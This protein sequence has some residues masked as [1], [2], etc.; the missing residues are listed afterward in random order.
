MARGLD[1]RRFLELCYAT[2]LGRPADARGVEGHLSSLTNQQ[3]DMVFV[4]EVFDRIASSPEYAQRSRIRALLEASSALAND[5]WNVVG[6]GTHCL[7]ATLLRDLQLRHFSLPFDW[8]FSSPEMV[9]HALHDDFAVFLDRSHH[10]TVPEHQRPTPGANLA[11]HT[12]YRENFGVD[13]VFNHH[14]PVVSDAAY[15]YLQRSVQRFRDLEHQEGRK[16]FVLINQ[17][18]DSLKTGHR[19]AYLELTALLK[20][21][22]HLFINVHQL[23]TALSGF[24]VVDRGPNYEVANFYSTSELKGIEFRDVEDYVSLARAVVHSLTAATAAN[25]RL[26]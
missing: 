8:I 4:S 10:V 7:T 14:D 20:G 23:P 13:Y 22:F 3:D 9:V 15:S 17:D 2:W 5:G 21:D 19:A 1:R 6:V 18:R 25:G 12:H 24:E 16:A 26:R 11:H